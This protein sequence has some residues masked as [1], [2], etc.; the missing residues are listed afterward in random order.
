MESGV[1]LI[2]VYNY[3][4]ENVHVR[5]RARALS[6]LVSDLLMSETI[7]N[8]KFHISPP[9]A[10]AHRLKKNITQK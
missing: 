4:Y 7:C 1:E 10:S 2:N 3:L 5:A 9:P 6:S 8:Q